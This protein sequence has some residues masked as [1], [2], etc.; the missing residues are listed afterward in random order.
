MDHAIQAAREGE[1]STA[2]AAALSSNASHI[3][4]A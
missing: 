2:Q 1:M 4:R 3:R